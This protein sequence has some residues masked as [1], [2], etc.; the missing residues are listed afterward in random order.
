MIG[1]KIQGKWLSLILSE[2]K[3]MEVRSTYRKL[4]GQRIAL[5]NSDNGLIEGYAT[6]S[7]ITEIEYSE[8]PKYHKYHLATPWLTNQY[9]DK[10]VVYGYLLKDVKRELNPEPYPKNYSIWFVKEKVPEQTEP[11]YGNTPYEKEQLLDE[12]NS[13]DL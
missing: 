4:I 2:E 10:S 9:K 6:V 13:D 12:D 1:L 3:T 5:G 8:I 7:N 11:F